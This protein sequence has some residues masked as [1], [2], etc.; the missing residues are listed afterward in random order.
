MTTTTTTE[1]INLTARFEAR[2]EA[3]RA[4]AKAKAVEYVNSELIPQLIK[5]ADAG[6][7]FT[8]KTPPRGTYIE[9]IF[10]ALGEKVECSMSTTGYRGQFSVSW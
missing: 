10:E 1:R 6:Q 4:E 7:R 2:E 8:V 5:L 9:D 3:K